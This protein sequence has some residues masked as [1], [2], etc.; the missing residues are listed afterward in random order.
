VDIDSGPAAK[1][2]NRRYNPRGSIPTIVIDDE[3]LIGF[4]S[5]RI[6]R[7]IEGAAKRR[8]R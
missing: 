5:T 6:N 3:V 1:A 2:A 4:S 7:A 8:M